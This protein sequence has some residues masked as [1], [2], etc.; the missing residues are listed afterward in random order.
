MASLPTEKLTNSNTKLNFT[1]LIK[2]DWRTND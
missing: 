1:Q 2:N